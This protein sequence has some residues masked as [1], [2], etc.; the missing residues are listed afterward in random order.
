MEV[1]STLS[2]ITPGLKVYALSVTTI[3]GVASQGKLHRLQE[4][5]V[6]KG[7]TQCGYCTPGMIMSTLDLVKENPHPSRIELNMPMILKFTMLYFV[8]LQEVH[9]LMQ[10]SSALIPQ[11]QLRFREYVLL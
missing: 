11:K 1:D 9:I 4:L 8:A 10:K 7:A 3:E 2:G 6:S 5:F